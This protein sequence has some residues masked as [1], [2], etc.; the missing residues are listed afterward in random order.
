MLAMKR[1]SGPLR[2]AMAMER[3]TGPMPGR[4]VVRRPTFRPSTIAYRSWNCVSLG[5]LSSHCLE[6]EGSVLDLMSSEVSG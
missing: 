4:R 6:T 5:V 1:K 2:F 3:E